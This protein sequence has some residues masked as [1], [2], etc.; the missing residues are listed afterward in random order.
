MQ[1]I[2][3]LSTI[4][5]YRSPLGR[6]H[7]LQNILIMSI[8][9]VMSGKSGFRELARFMKNNEAEFRQLLKLRHKVPSHVTLTA[10]FKGLDFSKFNAAFNSW[11]NQYVKLEEQE[12]LSIDGKAIASTTTDSHNSYQ[13]FVSLI[14]IFAS[15]RG[16]VVGCQKIEN[17]KASEIPTVK[18][19]IEKLDIENCIFTLDALH[20]QKKQ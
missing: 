5:D 1:L 13:N 14:S 6:R 15:K 3:V 17:A 9:G 12:L 10:V 19:L 11:A 16:L 8:L 7:S 2:E 20:C 18:E 4:E